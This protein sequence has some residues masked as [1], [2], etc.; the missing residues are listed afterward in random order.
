MISG[1]TASSISTGQ[2]IIIGGLV[3]QILFF[4]FFVVV[5]IIFQ[6][7]MGKT[8]TSSSTMIGLS[9]QKHLHT[10]YAASALVLIRSVFRVIEYKQGND[11]Y[12][13]GHEPFL[14]IFDAT[15]MLG[16]MILFNVVHPKEVSEVL[17]SLHRSDASSELGAIREQHYSN[18]S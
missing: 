10:L 7:R 18:K 14:Y 1:K 12:L 9:W 17:R 4:G 3:L 16:V 13:L 11:G 5:A 6:S 15:L 8:P 2:N